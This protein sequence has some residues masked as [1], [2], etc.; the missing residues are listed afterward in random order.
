MKSNRRKFFKQSAIGAIGVS[1]GSGFV[2]QSCAESAASS[3]E[4]KNPFLEIG[5]G[6]AEVDTQHGRVRGFVLNGI[7]TYL[8]LPYGA[9]TS[10]KNRFMPPKSPEAWEGVKE[11]LWWG[12]TAPQI[13]DGRFSNVEASFTDHWNYDALSEDCLRLNIW[14]PATD[15][16]KRPVLVWLHGGGYRNGNGIEQDGYHGE[17]LSRKGDVVFVSL[18]HRLGPIGFSNL[19]SAGSDYA[20][21]G[22]VGMLDIVK[23]LEWVRD[24]IASFGGDPGNVTIMGQSG[25]GAKV[26][27]LMA[28]PSAKGLFHKAVPLSGSTVQGLPKEYSESLG[29]YILKEVGGNANRLH[30]LSWREYLDV[31]YKANEKMTQEKGNS[32]LR[33]GGFGPVQNGVDIPEGT[34]F[35]EAGGLSSDVPMLISSTFHEWSPSRMDESLLQITFEGVEEKLKEAY[36]DDAGAVIAAFKSDF[37][38]AKPI[39]IYA[40]ILSNRS[41]LIRTANAKVK[42][43][44]PVYVAWFGWEPPMFNGR[45]KAFHCLDICFWF[46]NTDRMYTH[47]GGGQRPKALSEKMSDALLSFMKTGTPAANGLPEWKAYSEE[48]GE[49]MILNDTSELKENPDKVAREGLP[50]V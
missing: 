26:C 8:G 48:N 29:E 14:T 28:M 17:N 50:A 15:A 45:M 5:D 43:E 32:G 1:A 46:Y 23:A 11:T 21:S 31:A 36:G 47:T 10:G 22:N 16:K 19:A 44:A 4:S 3:T 12:D 2:L 49:T 30:E 33:R 39:D 34:Y 9:D 24:N 13:M 25:G 41:S 7:H 6:I 42:Q 38:N 37:P 35:S 18:N 20:S 27:T 40:M